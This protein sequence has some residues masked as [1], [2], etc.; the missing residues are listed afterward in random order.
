MAEKSDV[1]RAACG[2]A[3]M[4]AI[5]DEIWAMRLFLCDGMKAVDTDS[6]ASADR[7]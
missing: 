1:R 2:A 4:G 3:V 6:T 5:L 7:V